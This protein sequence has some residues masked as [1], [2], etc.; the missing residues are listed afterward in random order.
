M[1]EFT[2]IRVFITGKNKGDLF[3]IGVTAYDPAMAPG[4][5]PL[6]GLYFFG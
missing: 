6:R 2:P 4:I 1:N 3:N 5:A